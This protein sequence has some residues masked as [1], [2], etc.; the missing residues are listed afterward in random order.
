M[1]TAPADR[2]LALA[3][4]D[5]LARRLE[6]FTGAPRRVTLALARTSLRLSLLS[7]AVSL[8]LALAAGAAP[9]PA[10]EGI[11]HGASLTLWLSLASPCI[12]PMGTAAIGTVS[13]WTRRM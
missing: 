13:R 5:A 4:A 10:S 8:T 6:R 7:G 9:P 12:A 3:P 1:I 11:A 2:I